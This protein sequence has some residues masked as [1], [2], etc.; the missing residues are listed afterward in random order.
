MDAMVK[1]QVLLPQGDASGGTAEWLW[2]L[3]NGKD[4]FVIQNVPTFAFGISFGDTVEAPMDGGAPVFKRIVA[5]GGH[6]TYRLYAKSDI[7]DP[8]FQKVLSRLK[9][10][11][12]DLEVATQRIVG[13]DVLPAAD[14][15]AVYE[16]MQEAE[17][18]GI[19]EFEE[20]HCG[21][22]LRNT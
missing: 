22:Q 1:I 4:S 9:E 18:E 12:C 5:R 16:V 20:G 17:S 10:L 11:Q 21:H 6:S 14:I 15:Y 19:L 13:I 3:P 8:Q 7:H 2:A